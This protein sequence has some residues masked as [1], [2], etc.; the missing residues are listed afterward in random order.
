MYYLGLD[1][2][3]TGCKSML[4]DEK[5]GIVGEDYIEYD[6][7]Y[8]DNGIV[9]Q[10]PV[11]LWEMTKRTVK[12]T[13]AAAGVPENEIKSM[14]ISAQGISFVPVDKNGKELGNI[15]SWLDTRA[16]K[17]TK[18]IESVLGADY[19]FKT[20]GKRINT[21]YTLPKIMWLKENSPD[22]YQNTYKFLMVLDY[23][24]YKF[25][26]EI[27]TD[28]SMAGGTMM[29]DIT[30][31]KWDEKILNACAI[32]ADKLPEVSEAGTQAGKIQENTALELGLSTDTEVI[33]GAQDQKCAALGAGIKEGVATVSLGTSTAIS[34]L[35][36]E[37]VLDKLK[38]IPCF[39]LNETSWILE[40]VIGTSGAAFK[41]M[42]NL[43]EMGYD[44]M[45]RLAEQSPP[46]SDGVFF[47]PHFTGRG[48]RT[49]MK[50]PEARFTAS[51]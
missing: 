39:A 33:L 16:H 8:S 11:E 42:R 31:H 38:R 10:S 3:T 18:Q 1:I 32:D 40:A 48:A 46:G 4:F 28:Y 12:S 51:H 25:T 49:G 15:I 27:K 6:L 43:F 26:G 50:K 20:T 34:V 5:L 7:I 44:D 36:K 19:I 22:V 30:R 29:F 47:Y 35:S 14:S 9:E 23:I 17:Q 21:A 24:T 37:P 41:W 45:S 13:L 2:G